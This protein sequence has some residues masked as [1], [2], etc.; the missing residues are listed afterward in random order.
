M[1]SVEAYLAAGDVT[2][3]P[4]WYARAASIADRLIN[5]HA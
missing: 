5:G 4:V 3:N 1:H 2:A